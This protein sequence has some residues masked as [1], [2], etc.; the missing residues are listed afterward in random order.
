MG[1]G[2]RRLAG[3]G[4]RAGVVCRVRTLWREGAVRCWLECAVR[5]LP[6]CSGPP[7]HSNITRGLPG[8][9]ID[10]VWRGAAW[11]TGPPHR[12]PSAMLA[13]HTAHCTLHTAHCTLHTAH[14][15]TNNI[16]DQTE[17]SLLCRCGV[18]RARATLIS[19]TVNCCNLFIMNLHPFCHF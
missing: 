5:G 11:H 9:D 8:S 1:G 4:P 10:L 15:T 18:P 12:T 2:L 7:H 16:S 6:G 3:S 13:L 19:W 14:W 17:Y